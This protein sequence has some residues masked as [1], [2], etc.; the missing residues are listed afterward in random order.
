M[1][2]NGIIAAGFT[3]CYVLKIILLVFLHCETFNELYPIIS[4]RHQ[5]MLNDVYRVKKIDVAVRL[6]MSNTH[7]LAEV[8]LKVN[9]GGA[10]GCVTHRNVRCEFL[11]VSSYWWLR[12]SCIVC[13]SDLALSYRAALQESDAHVN[14]CKGFQNVYSTFTAIWCLRSGQTVRLKEQI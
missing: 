14:L 4:R 9:W 12:L 3:V 7:L 10:T 6:F 2:G 11:P 5:I 8:L 13:N 1:F